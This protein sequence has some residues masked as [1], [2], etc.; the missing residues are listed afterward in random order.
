MID[1][2]RAG[3][4]RPQA[5]GDMQNMRIDNFNAALEAFHPKREWLGWA[6]PRV[7]AAVRVAASA[8]RRRPRAALYATVVGAMVLPL[9]PDLF[10]AIPW[11]YRKA[12]GFVAF[13]AVSCVCLGR[14]LLVRAGDDLPP[15]DDVRSP[16]WL[17][18]VLPLACRAGGAAAAGSGE[19][20]LLRLGPEPAEVRVGPADD[21]ALGRVPLVGPLVPGRVPAGGQPAVRRGRVATPLVLAFGTSVGLRLATLACL[22]IA[23]EGAR[24]LALMWVGRPVRGGGRRADLR[25]QRRRPAAS[26]VRLSPADELPDVPLAALLPLPAGASRRRRA[27]A[28]LLAGLRPPERD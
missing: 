7:L 18:L 12:A 24:R 8:I 16:R 4:S 22:L 23:A 11:P 10:W 25:P 15:A 26:R 13:L 27:L 3:P 2:S 14:L 9:V 6:A 19:P 5:Q 21:P 28:G 17:T 1:A 20:G